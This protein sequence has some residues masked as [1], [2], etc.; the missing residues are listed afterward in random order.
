MKNTT[1]L[2][3]L[4][5]VSAYSTTAFTRYSAHEEDTFSL[6]LLDAIRENNLVTVE[7]LIAAG[8]D[9]DITDRWGIS[10]LHLAIT[11]ERNAVLRALL[12]AGADVNIRDAN[13]TTPLMQAALYGYY[14]SVQLLLQ[15]KAKVNLQDDMGHTAL[16]YAVLAEHVDIVRLLLTAQ[17][18]VNHKTGVFGFRNTGDT[19]LIIA[20]R[21]LNYTIMDMLLR[22]GADRSIPGKHGKTVDQILAEQQSRK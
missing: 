18:N 21:F 11:P 19:P 10:A 3:T 22:A 12:A 14:L 20:A 7:G 16:T 2:T 8:V 13:N 5:L 6:Q 15:A 17:A 4:L 1:L 9:V